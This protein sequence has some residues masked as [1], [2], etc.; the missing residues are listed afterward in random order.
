MFFDSF[1]PSLN[2]DW[3]ADV[4]IIGSGPCAIAMARS[5]AGPACKVLLVEAGGMEE[6]S[7]SVDSL[8]GDT[9][10]LDYPLQSTRARQFGGSTALWAGYCALF[11]KVDFDKHAW[12]HGSGWPIDVDSLETHYEEATKLLN[13]PDADFSACEFPQTNDNRGVSLTTG[14][15]F[16][17]VW[18]FGKPKANFASQYR[19]VLELSTQIDVLVNATVNDIRLSTKH[20]AVELI[21]ATNSNGNAIRITADKYIVAAGGIETPRLLLASNRQI[22]PGVGNEHDQVGR[23]FMEHPHVE[24]S[25]I[26]LDGSLDFD[27]WARMATTSDGRRFTRCFGVPF[28]VQH[29][30][31]VLN[32]RAHFFRTPSMSSG[33]IPR[34]GVFFEQAA[35]PASR[36]RLSKKLDNLGIPRIELDWQLCELDLHSHK[37]VTE[38]IADSLVRSKIAKRSSKNCNQTDVLHSN[39]QLGTT[40]MSNEPAAGVVDSNC[41]VHGLSNLY[42]AGGSVFPTVSWANPTLTVLALGLRLAAHLKS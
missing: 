1:D 10:G 12:K 16:D 28:D 35:N 40:R 32:A 27:E 7:S 34:A 11:D 23:Y 33:A 20:N 22:E 8:N 39:H 29:Q 37:E 17:A 36:I 14:E 6:S 41:K 38:Y 30:L 31:K 25:G 2:H 15:L 4:A 13:L 9:R 21:E 18:R 42:I 26:E 24:I 5:L 3:S 19:R